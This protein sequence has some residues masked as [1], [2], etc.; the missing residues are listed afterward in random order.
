MGFDSATEQA[1]RPSDKEVSQAARSAP[2]LEQN[3]DPAAEYFPHDEQRTSGDG[4][5]CGDDVDT[6]NGRVIGSRVL[7]DRELWLGLN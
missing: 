7:G 4:A 6:S 2:Q 3:F 5:S 1:H